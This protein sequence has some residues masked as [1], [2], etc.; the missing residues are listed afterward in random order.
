MEA[1]ESIL[2]SEYFQQSTLQLSMALG[3]TANQTLV[4]EAETQAL[5]TFRYFTFGVALFRIFFPLIAGALV[6]VLSANTDFPSYFLT[7]LQSRLT[8]FFA[9]VPTAPFLSL[10]EDVTYTLWL[11]FLISH[12]LISTIADWYFLWFG[13]L[14]FRFFSKHV[15]TDLKYTDL[16]QMALI[17]SL[18]GLIVSMLSLIKPAF[19]YK[20]YESTGSEDSLWE[21]FKYLFPATLA[22]AAQ[23]P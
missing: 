13:M 14:P 2:H 12:Y 18:F 16:A 15:A 4:I 1:L 9:S 10:V 8:A 23:I 6:L 17:Y 3:Q 19:S 22:I 21:A 7:N 11:G 5:R 20:D